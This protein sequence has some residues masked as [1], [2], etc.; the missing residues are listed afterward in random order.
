MTLGEIAVVAIVEE[1]HT[2]PSSHLAARDAISACPS[3]LG[4][5]VSAPPIA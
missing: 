1:A 5:T 3:W 4:W 2:R